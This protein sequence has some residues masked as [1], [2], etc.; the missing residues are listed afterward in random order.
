MIQ[1]GSRARFAAEAVDG[2][3]VLGNVFGKKFQSDVT[4]EPG[5]LGSID[6][7]HA[8]AAK[9]FDDGVMGN[10]TTDNGEK[11]PPLAREFTPATAHG[12]SLRTLEGLL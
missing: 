6:N 11:Y 2:L 12:Q 1:G 10:R 7:A 4:A 8:S 5:V 3:R 9:F